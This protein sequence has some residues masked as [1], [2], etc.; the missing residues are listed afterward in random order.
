MYAFFLG[1]FL[2]FFQTELMQ[3]M[4]NRNKFAE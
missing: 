3:K 2:I 1:G 4:L